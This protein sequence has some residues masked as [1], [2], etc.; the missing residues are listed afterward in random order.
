MLMRKIIYI[1]LVLTAFG[2]GSAKAQIDT[3]RMTIIGRNAL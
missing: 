1:L 3:D 2:G